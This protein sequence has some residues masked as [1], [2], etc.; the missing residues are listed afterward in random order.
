MHWRQTLLAT[1]SIIH[2]VLFTVGRER[3]LGQKVFF[4]AL[5]CGNNKADEHNMI[6]MTVSEQ[7]NKILTTK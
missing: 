4:E 7:V 2:Q 5:F 6:E 1:M 3:S